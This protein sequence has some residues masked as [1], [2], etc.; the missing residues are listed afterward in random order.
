MSIVKILDTLIADFLFRLI[1]VLNMQF[2]FLSDEHLPLTSHK[3]KKIVCYKYVH[4]HE[5]T[6]PLYNLSVMN[7]MPF[8][9]KFL[10]H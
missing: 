2:P 1:V 7:D 5:W 8:R 4:A 3:I 9:H 10:C 6:F